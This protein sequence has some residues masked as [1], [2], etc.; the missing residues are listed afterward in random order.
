MSPKFGTQ[1]DFDLPNRAKSPEMKSEVEL[2]RR[3]PHLKNRCDVITLLDVY[4]F[5]EIGSPRPL[6]MRIE[7]AQTGPMH[8]PKTANINEET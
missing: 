3:G 4:D 7:N 6:N 1:V 8:V 2:P 5:D